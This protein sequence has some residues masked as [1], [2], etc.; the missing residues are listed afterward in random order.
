[1][2]VIDELAA[3]LPRDVGAPFLSV[4]EEKCVTELRLRADRPARAVWYGGERELGKPMDGE[5]LRAVI[6]SMLEHSRYAWEDELGQGYFTLRGGCRVGVT[7]RFVNADGEIRLPDVG[8]ACV[9]VARP[10]PGCARPL[11]ARVIRDG[12]AESTLILSRPGMGKTTML[13]DAARLMSDGG[14]TVAVADERGEIAA[15]RRGVPTLDVGAR[16]DVADGIDK[17]ASMMRLI[18][19]MAPDVLVTDEIGDI[20]DLHAAREASRTGV[21]LFA[22]AHAGSIEEARARPALGRLIAEGVFAKIALLR[23][24]PGRLCL[25]YDALKGETTWRSD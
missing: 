13:R 22:S 14:L 17:R 20:R 21:A 18:R 4:S 23:G 2:G 12:R 5:R 15:C 9:R 1:M 8:S 3:Y 7:G 19:S 11:L 6:S 16:T 25:L 24:G 10:V